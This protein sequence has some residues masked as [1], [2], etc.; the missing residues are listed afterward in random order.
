M[1][2]SDAHLASIFLYLEDENE[3][4]LKNN[5]YCSAVDL[6][7]LL[8]LLLTCN[9]MYMYMYIVCETSELVCHFYHTS[10]IGHLYKY[11]QLCPA[12]YVIAILEKMPGFCD[13]RIANAC[14]FFFQS[15]LLCGAGAG[16][17]EGF[18]VAPFERVKTSLQVQT[19]RMSE[20]RKIK[21]TQLIQYVSK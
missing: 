11:I 17:T 18:L 10:M 1:Q 20:V 21:H 14:T 2:N 4:Q 15:P 6:P 5:Y 19:A 8:V 16:V 3:L 12:R 7:M 9:Y 13:S